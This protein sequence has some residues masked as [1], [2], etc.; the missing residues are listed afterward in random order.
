MLSS[1]CSGKRDGEYRQGGRGVQQVFLKFFAVILPR[2]FA[3]FREVTDS[4]ECSLLI[5]K[6]PAT[7]SIQCDENDGPAKLQAPTSKLQRNFKLQA[8]NWRVYA[9]FGA[10]SLVHLWMLELG[11]WCLMVASAHPTPGRN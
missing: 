2:L 7:V 4:S 1:S 3:A 9:R 10:W 6:L 8:P 5:Q 11:I